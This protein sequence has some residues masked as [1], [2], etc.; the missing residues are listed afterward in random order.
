MTN[1]EIKEALELIREEQEEAMFLRDEF[2]KRVTKLNEK[3]HKYQ[4]VIIILESKIG[5]T[6]DE[7]T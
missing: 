5:G 4:T 3:I 7:A 1:K 6:E 2:N